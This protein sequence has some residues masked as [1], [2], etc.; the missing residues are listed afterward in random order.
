[1]GSPGSLT[2]NEVSALELASALTI[3]PFA[4]RKEKGLVFVELTVP[5]QGVAYIT[6]ELE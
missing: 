2:P 5:P 4:T 1:M 3:E 6:L